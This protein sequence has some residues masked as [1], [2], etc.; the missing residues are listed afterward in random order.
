MVTGTPGPM[1]TAGQRIAP[2][3]RRTQPWETALPRT[4]MFV[5]LCKAIWTES[6]QSAEGR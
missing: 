4:P 1:R 6:S 3:P 2:F 5:S